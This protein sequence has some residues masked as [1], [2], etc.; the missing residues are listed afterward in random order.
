[1]E[2]QI[3]DF[4]WLHLFCLLVYCL[5]TYM[6]KR[7]NLYFF[8]WSD[9]II[10]WT[11]TA[12]FKLAKS[13]F[14]SNVFISTSHLI[15]KQPSKGRGNE[16][17]EKLLKVSQR[18]PGEGNGNSLQ[19]SCLENPMDRGTWLAT[20]HG[21]QKNKK[22]LSDETATTKSKGYW[23]GEPNFRTV[24]LTLLI[25]IFSPCTPCVQFQ[26]TSA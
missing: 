22:K 14:Y 4:K 2:N 26:L 23:V 21:L 3:L 6:L 13:Q 1:M 15:F 19:N 18:S 20:L 11:K 16:S 12:K 17:K 7:D 24:T 25:T 5:S 10:T 8:T 9:T